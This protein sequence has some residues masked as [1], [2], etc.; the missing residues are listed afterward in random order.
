[1]PEHLHLL[2]RPRSA[3]AKVERFLYAVKRPFSFRVKQDL[4]AAGEPLLNQLT[5]VERPGKQTFRFWQEGPGHDRN[6]IEPEAVLAVIDY[7]H[8]NPVKRG[9]CESPE[10]WRWSSWRYYHAPGLPTPG[11]PT[12]HRFSG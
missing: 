6:L 8:S 5:V 10:A 2:V 1:M 11:L 3:A 4:T 7:I 12:V 9:L